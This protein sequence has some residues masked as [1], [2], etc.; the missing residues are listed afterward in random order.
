MALTERT[1]KGVALTEIELDNN[2][3]CHY[4]IGSLYLSASPAIDSP[5][6]LIG[7][8]NWSKFAKGRALVS[9]TVAGREAG[10]DTN[11]SPGLGSNSIPDY[12]YGSP[13]HILTEKELPQH[14]HSWESYEG[15]GAF[16]FSGNYSGFDFNTNG[17]NIYRIT[18]P[19]ETGEVSFTNSPQTI[20]G[21]FTQK[22]GQPH[23]NLQPYIVVNIWKR[24]S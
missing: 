23:N 13:S 11:F 14:T 8:G 2:F 10:S 5:G 15:A 21:S 6:A 16:R 17:T 3:L 4:P 12:P 7:Y 1:K 9:S 18:R 24:D 20:S 22:V 19:G